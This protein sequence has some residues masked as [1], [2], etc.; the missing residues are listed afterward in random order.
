MS[1]FNKFPSS[2]YTFVNGERGVIQNISAYVEMLDE[3][4]TNSAFYKNYYIRN[5]DRPDN[6]S[7]EVYENPQLHWTFYIM[8][9]HLR[10]QGWPLDHLDI[11]E[12]AKEDFPYVSLSTDDTIAMIFKIGD[13]V[14]GNTSEAIGTII[15]RNLELGQLIVET[16]NTKKFQSDELLNLVGSPSQLQL[17]AAEDQYLAANHYLQD[18]DIY[19]NKDDL[20]DGVTY[21]EVTNLD[22]YIQENDKLRQIIIL[23]PTS[24]NKV[25]QMFR[26]A[27]KT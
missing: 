20:T 4:K 16:S 19:T 12:K 23:K 15:D 2:L 22:L 13:T 17:T 9:D 24:V 14:E 18:G 25:V 7:F 1:Y 27:I 6:V 11:I 21:V 26:E 5:G 8:N 3:V 10:E